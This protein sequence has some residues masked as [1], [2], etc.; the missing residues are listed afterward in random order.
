[1]NKA[2]IISK[3]KMATEFGDVTYFLALKFVLLHTSYKCFDFDHNL[4]HMQHM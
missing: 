3:K 2:V 4:T 1:M